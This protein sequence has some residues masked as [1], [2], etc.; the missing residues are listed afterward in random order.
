MKHDRIF[1]SIVSIAGIPDELG[2]AL[3]RIQVTVRGPT[4]STWTSDQMDKRDAKPGWRL[5]ALL[6][7]A[8]S[9]DSKLVLAL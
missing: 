9:F 2:Q 4:N 7:C 6:C 1:K 5:E 8:C 3:P